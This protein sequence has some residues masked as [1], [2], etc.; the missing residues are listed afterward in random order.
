M[1]VNGH[2]VEKSSSGHRKTHTHTHTHTHTKP[3]GALKGRLTTHALVDIM[4]HWN[5]AVDEGQSVRAVFVD[6]A[7]AFDHVD[8]NVLVAKLTKFNMPDMIIQ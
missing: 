2:L 1:L 4:H 6:Y 7:K 8:H 5:K 3:N